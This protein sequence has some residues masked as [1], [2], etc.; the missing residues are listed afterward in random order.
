M[1]AGGGSEIASAGVRGTLNVYRGSGGPKSRT[2]S[3]VSKVE[4]RHVWR[5]FRYSDRS[6]EWIGF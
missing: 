5:C 2:G 1:G 4:I 6:L 3:Y